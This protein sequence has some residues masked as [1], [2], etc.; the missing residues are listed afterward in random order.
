MIQEGSSQ[1]GPSFLFGSDV[2]CVTSAETGVCMAARRKRPSKL[3]PFLAQIGKSPDREIAVLAGVS[4]DAVRMYRQRHKIVSFRAYSKQLAALAPPSNRPS[5][6]L[7]PRPVQLGGAQRAFLLRVK[8]AKK[9][10]EWVIL[11]STIA[12]AAAQ[13]EA[14]NRGE[15][16]SLR[17]LGDLLS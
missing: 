10:T 12:A 8:T 7:P 3:D 17:Y 2:L 15:V 5:G 14:A 16:L 4:A 11:A 1:D 6:S 13:A 9:E